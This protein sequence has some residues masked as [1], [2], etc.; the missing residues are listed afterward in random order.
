MPSWSHPETIRCVFRNTFAWV[1]EAGIGRS[2]SGGDEGDH[3][4]KVFTAVEVFHEFGETMP[5]E[6]N[7][8]TLQNGKENATWRA[9]SPRQRS[10]R[11]ANSV[12]VDAPGP[13]AV[14]RNNQ[15]FV[16]GSKN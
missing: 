8:W 2:R 11:L 1:I 13:S 12:N 4:L 7:W 15:V 10:R 3:H 16:F 9:G 5:E 6:S 14:Q